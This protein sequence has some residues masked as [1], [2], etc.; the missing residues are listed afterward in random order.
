MKRDYPAISKTFRYRYEVT[1]MSESW[2]TLI[3]FWLEF[4]LMKASE[5]I[6]C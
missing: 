3:D 6:Q 4:V 2:T 1:P 5:L